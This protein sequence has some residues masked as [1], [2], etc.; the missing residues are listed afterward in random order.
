MSA[1][2]ET[3]ELLQQYLLFHYG[4]PDDQLPWEFGP[5]EA[6][7]FPV[8][9]VTRGVASEKLPG[10]ARALDIGCAVGRATFELA[11][12]FDEVMGI[13]QQ[14]VSALEYAHGRKL[15]HR[16][17]KPGNIL[18][19][20]EG[21]VKVVDFGL[22]KR[23]VDSAFTISAGASGEPRA[24]STAIV[25]SSPSPILKRLSLLFKM[26]P[27]FSAKSLPMPASSVRLRPG[28]CEIDATA[29]L[30]FSTVRAALRYARMRKGFAP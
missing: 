10:H 26:R 18:V 20:E 14:V 28:S 12:I 7:D 25:A 15:L 16:D 2:Y 1:T 13:G 17:I 6:L 11:R 23:L 8:R 22:A 4:T 30:R 21:R 19:V 24:C 3:D 5:R 29:S 9:C 27:I